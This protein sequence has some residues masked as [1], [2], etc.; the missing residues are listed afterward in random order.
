MVTVPVFPPFHVHDHHDDHHDDHHV[1]ELEDAVTHTLFHHHHHFSPP[2][3]T[4]VDFIP[5]ASAPPP[6]PPVDPPQE[7]EDAGEVDTMPRQEREGQVK[8]NGQVRSSFNER[9]SRVNRRPINN[10]RQMKRPRNRRLENQVIPPR[11][12][13]D[14]CPPDLLPLWHVPDDHEDIVFVH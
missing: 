1:H 7:E 12:T 6:P 8:D 4:P 5:V 3:A 10:I 14:E 11:D 2:M 13:I 9:A